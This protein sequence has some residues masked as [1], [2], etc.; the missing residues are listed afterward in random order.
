MKLICDDRLI[1]QLEVLLQGSLK[2][3]KNTCILNFLG[4]TDNSDLLRPVR[5]VFW[6]HCD[7]KW[8]YGNGYPFE[9]FNCEPEWHRQR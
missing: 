2:Y 1:D 8:F 4:F 6:T 9:L 3:N 7:C 5:Y